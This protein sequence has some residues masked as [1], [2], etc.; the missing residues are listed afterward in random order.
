MKEK[1][2]T[3]LDA[4]NQVLDL[5]SKYNHHHTYMSIPI[6]EENKEYIQPNQVSTAIPQ[7][8]I[9]PPEPNKTDQ[10]VVLEKTTPPKALE[11]T[12]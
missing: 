12:P 2:L 8:A 11:V 1:Y 4:Y 7:I 9:T 5:P 10:E 3:I 6:S